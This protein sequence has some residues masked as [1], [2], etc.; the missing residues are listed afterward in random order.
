MAEPRA[1]VTPAGVRDGDEETLASLCD[2]RG[3]AVLAYCEHVCG[4]GDAV[5]AAANAFAGFRAAV[6]AAP[7][8]A[9]VNPEALLVSATRH[10]AAARAPHPPAASG[11][12]AWLRAGRTRH[13]TC[14]LVPDLLVARA[15]SSLSAD[16]EAKLVQH[17]GRCSTCRRAQDRFRAAEAAYR[18]APYQRVP[19]MA[20]RRIVRALR[21]AAPVSA[22]SDAGNGN[23]A[24]GPR[25]AGPVSDSPR[26]PG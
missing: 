5:S 23:G 14:E 12:S 21:D 19:D 1:P 20:A 10:A 9:V 18:R 4:P 25:R 2:R 26:A 7:S 16:D 11:P 24:A 6:V 22:A 15:E 13:R 3:S 8:P 17:V